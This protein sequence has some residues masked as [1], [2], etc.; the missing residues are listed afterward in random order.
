VD[1]GGTSEQ[2]QRLV[3]ARCQRGGKLTI[4]ASKN[5][6]ERPTLAARSTYALRWK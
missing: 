6:K 1:V 2:Q 3:T 4:F 5:R